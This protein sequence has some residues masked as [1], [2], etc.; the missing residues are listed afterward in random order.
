MAEDTVKRS[1]RARLPAASTTLCL[2][3]LSRQQP[4]G[5]LTA[6]VRSGGPSLSASREPSSSLQLLGL[7]RKETQ[8]VGWKVN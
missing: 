7:P 1:R 4:G 6:T 5:G 2:P 3:A 8:V